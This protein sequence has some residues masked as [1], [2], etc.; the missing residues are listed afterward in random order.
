MKLPEKLQIGGLD[1]AIEHG[2]VA[3]ESL[4]R[5]ITVAMHKS[6]DS[7][8]QIASWLS[9]QTQQ[10]VFWQNVAYAINYVYL[11]SVIDNDLLKSLGQ[12]IYQIVEQVIACPRLSRVQIGG[13]VYSIEKNDVELAAESRLGSTDHSKCRILIMSWLS[14]QQRNQVFWH[15]GTHDVDHIYLGGKLKE[16][17]VDSFGQGLYQVVRQLGIELVLEDEGAAA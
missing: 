2:G 1:Y 7:V 13:V 17:E 16:S 3:D 10:T 11:D 8:I 6:T 15:E 14:P 5:D 4:M 12:G 9:E